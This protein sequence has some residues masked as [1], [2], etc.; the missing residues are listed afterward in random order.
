MLE[1]PTVKWSPEEI[2]RLGTMSDKELARKMGRS[3]GAIQ[4]KHNQLR[5]ASI[6]SHS[7][8]QAH[9]LPKAIRALRACFKIAWGPAAR[10]EHPLSGL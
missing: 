1:P 4:G 9:P 6:R 3:Y 10:P 8:K 7:W 2:K 5:I